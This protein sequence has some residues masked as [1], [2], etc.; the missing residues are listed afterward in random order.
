MDMKDLRKAYRNNEKLITDL[1]SQYSIR[2]TTKANKTIYDLTVISLRAEIQNILY[3][4]KYEKLDTSV[5]A[6]NTIC[7]K[8]VKL[9]CD[10]N[11]N[12]AGTLTKYIGEIE[13]L[14]MMN[15]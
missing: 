10:D 4:L 12:I 3:N 7:E 14:L 6:V 11:Q 2:Y 9:T 1:L 13:Y 15:R 8:Y 5:N